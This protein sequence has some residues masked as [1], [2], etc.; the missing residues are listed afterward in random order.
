MI[1]RP[2]RSTLFP[3]TT[4]FRSN[5]ATDADI[6]AVT[7]LIMANRR[8]HSPDYLDLAQTKLKDIWDYSTA[9]IAL[10]NDLSGHYLLPG[11][12]EAFHPSP[13]IWYLNPSYIAPYAF[14]LFAQ[15]DQQHD[16]LE[17]VDTGYRMLEGSS[18]L[19]DLGLPSDWVLLHSET[20]HYR[21]LPATA[22]I[23]SL[24]GFDAYRVWWRVALD[25]TWFKS[26]PAGHY[27]SDH[28]SALLDRWQ[29]FQQLPAQIDL[30][31]Q[32]MVDYGATSQYAMIYQAARHLDAE[33]AESIRENTLTL[34]DPNDFWDGDSAYYTQNLAWLGLYPPEWVP[35]DWLSAAE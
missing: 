21:A 22:P 8:W 27:L 1:R 7:A 15:I 2:P 14:R 32:A 35:T 30:S 12:I 26:A 25:L 17:L 11:P 13:E 16:W 31:G 6:D 5:F 10:T 4:L 3:Y 18:Q 29:Q 24:Y 23:R 33:V 28:L 34:A 9:D 19:S 20:P